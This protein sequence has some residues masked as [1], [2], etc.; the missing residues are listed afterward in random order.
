MNELPTGWARAALGEATTVRKEKED[1]RN[2]PNLPFIG[3]E[4]VEAHTGRII[5]T[6]NT[7]ALRSAVAI[8]AKG[9]ILYG[10]LRPYLN[11]VVIPDFAGA[12]SAE[13]I[14]F[15]RSKLLE[16]RYLQRVLMSPAFVEFT[17]STST[18]DRPRVSYESMSPYVFPLPPV[19]E[20]HRIV[21]KIDS[22]S[23]K[24][25]RARDQLDHVPRLV[26]K[27]KEAIIA[28]AFR[29]ELTS[30]M[31]GAD[32]AC[33]SL[34]A[35]RKSALASKMVVRPWNGRKLAD[36]DLPQVPNNWRWFLVG[37][38]VIHRA[39]IA[40][41]SDDFGTKGNQVVRL[42]NLYQGNLDLS[43]QPVFLKDADKYHAFFATTGDL[44]VSQ[45][46]TK[47][48]RDYGH[49]VAVPEQVGNL[50]INQRILCL[51]CIQGIDPK[52]LLFYSRTRLFREY[53]FS[54]ETGGV[55]QGNVGVSGI[56]D[57]PIPLPPFSEQAE[58]VRRIEKAFTWI[59]G[60][61][62]ETTSARKLIDHLDQAVL[63][64]AFRGELVPQDPED[65]PASVL[66]ERI[67]AERSAERANVK[68][69]QKIQTR[70]AP[71]RQTALSE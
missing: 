14:V 52:F 29:G 53:F 55:N 70:R 48:K 26:E 42:G 22:V 66:L 8:F 7:S 31:Q 61:A 68:R 59:D 63:A 27:Y 71:A 58:I 57:A 9:D 13:F 38:I 15:P 23:A 54:K 56:M 34:I 39:G 30:D 16:P 1:P 4:E 6:Q 41:Q 28:A 10:R 5:S 17:T 69:G 20:Q 45:T 12:A 25:K 51:T 44:L 67:R 11:K 33:A 62:S 36:E 40:F 43:R 46:G 2:L 18:G 32:I 50:L 65:E 47:Y 21:A 19:K 64:K 3:L 60:L 24:S 37:D 35:K 49:F